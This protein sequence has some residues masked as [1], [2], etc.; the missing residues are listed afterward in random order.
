[1]IKRLLAAF[2]I[3][4]LLGIP[5]TLAEDTVIE[6]I[7]QAETEELDI[8]VPDDLEPGYHEMVIEVIDENDVVGEKLIVLCK[9]YAGQIYWDGVCPEEPVEIVPVAELEQIE[10][11]EDLPKYDAVAEPEKTVDTQVAVFAVLSAVAAGA[12][13][14]GAASGSGAAQSQSRRGDD[15]QR[16]SDREEDREEERQAGEVASADV[17]KLDAVKRAVGRGDASTLWQRAYRPELETGLVAWTERVSAFSPMG[18]RILQDGSYLRA[19]L[20]G[21]GL[22]PSMLGIIVGIATLF[23]TELQAM[24]PSFMLVAISLVLSTLDAMAGLW[25]SAIVLVGTLLS[26]NVRSLDEAMTI[27]GVAAVLLTP[28]LVASAIRPFRREVENLASGWERGTDYLLAVLL[29]GWTVEKFVGSLNGLAGVQ[30]AITG[31]ARELGLLASALIFLRLVLE[32]VAT[33]NFPQRLT[34]QDASLR[35]PLKAQ[36]VVSLFTK[37]LLFFLVSYQFLGLTQQ[38]LIGTALFALPQAIKL[39]E[40]LERDVNIVPLHFILPKGAPKIIV[41]VFV[42]AFFAN[43]VQGLFPT[44]ESFVLWS[45]VV[46]S[47]PGLV[48]SLLTIVSGAPQ[49]DWRDSTVG[50]WLYRAG[51]VVV[52]GLIFAMYRGVDLYAFVFGG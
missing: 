24:P 35:D 8:E 36:A 22:V 37:T 25:I 14:V 15:D 45:F 43:W 51:G 47:I 3:V 50:T 18:A 1:M 16:K 28:G 38:L 48:L 44:P 42:G 19:M 49:R 39:Y 26:G 41:M 33:Y 23:D 10:S 4:F 6:Q 2:F 7:T 31:S 46:L 21:F 29:G 30:L 34:Q 40:K 32:D 27:F 9:D 12:S 17:S 13:A 5:P 52:A 20:S 11:R